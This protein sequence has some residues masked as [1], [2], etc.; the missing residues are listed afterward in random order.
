MRYAIAKHLGLVCCVF[1]RPLNCKSAT[2]AAPVELTVCQLVSNCSQFDHKRV[3]FK[4]EFLSDGLESSSLVDPPNCSQGIQPWTSKAVDR[5]SDIKALD[6]ALAKG[7]RGTIDKQVVGTFTGRY[8][9]SSATG[10]KGPR[11]L[12]IESIEGLTVTPRKPE[13]PEQS[14]KTSNRTQIESLL[15]SWEKRTTAREAAL[16]VGSESEVV[17]V[18]GA[19]AESRNQAFG[20]RS[21]A[22]ALLATFKSG[23]SVKA[24]ARVANT[25]NPTY[26]C[27]AIQALAEIA[28]KA[29]LPVLVSKLD[30]HSVC[31]QIQSTDPARTSNVHVSDEAVRALEGVTG[32][33]FGHGSSN[34]HR[35][36]EPWKEWWEKQQQDT[37][38]VRTNMPMQNKLS[39][40]A[41]TH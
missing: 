6:A 33:T 35:E 25:A 32:H 29:T 4:A 20:R 1:L 31:M 10:T 2:A 5:H 28:S 19:I 9:C 7:Y 39:A 3:R 18:L 30:D 17:R 26:R 15:D 13:S 11:I 38:R 36:T 40:V 23:L 34:G 22:I 21:H 12:H 41:M 27:G 37:E 8:E 14:S 24:L 16:K